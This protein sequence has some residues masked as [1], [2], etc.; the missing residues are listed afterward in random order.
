MNGLR[1]ISTNRKV[2][3]KPNE[4]HYFFSTVLDYINDY[5]LLIKQGELFG[6]GFPED[7]LKILEKEYNKFILE[8]NGRW[9]SVDKKFLTNFSQ[10]I[11]DGWVDIYGIKNIVNSLDNFIAELNS[12]RKIRKEYYDFLAKNTDFIFY[13][14]DDSYWEIF[15]NDN[16]LLSKI[17]ENLLDK[18]EINVIK[19]NI[20]NRPLI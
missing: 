9:L 11:I 14:V 6:F 5:Y 1:V 12:Y 8:K 15:S 17:E 7:K 2:T 13:N 3:K 10:Y 19:D 18:D 20:F 16:T 4:F